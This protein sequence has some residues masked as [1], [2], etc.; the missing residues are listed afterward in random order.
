MC[1][2][3][4]SG[5]R[6]MKCSLSLSTTIESPLIELNS[7]YKNKNK[8]TND[9]NNGE[10]CYDMENFNYLT[11]TKT[12]IVVFIKH[13]S[14]DIN[15]II[16]TFVFVNKENNN[17]LNKYLNLFSNNSIELNVSSH[18]DTATK[19]HTYNQITNEKYIGIIVNEIEF[20]QQ[21]KHTN[22]NL[23]VGNL[24]DCSHINSYDNG[25]Y[26]TKMHEIFSWKSALTINLIVETYVSVN[27]NIYIYIGIN[28]YNEY[29]LVGNITTVPTF[30]QTL[31]SLPI[32]ISE[33][34][35]ASIS[36]PIINTLSSHTKPPTK[37]HRKTPSSSTN[38][39][40]YSPSI[41][42]TV[43]ITYSTSLAPSDTPSL[44][45]SDTPA[46]ALTI[47]RIPRTT[48]PTCSHSLAPGISSTVSLMYNGLS[49]LVYA[50]NQAYNGTG[51]MGNRIYN[52][53]YTSLEYAFNQPATNPSYIPT[54]DAT[55]ILTNDPTSN[56]IS[57]MYDNICLW[58]IG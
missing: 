23:N 25:T 6:N 14:K 15:L 1:K 28:I 5:T 12:K 34:I 16:Q 17:I 29:V 39:S 20:Y 57:F 48:E 10:I 56:V 45:Q 7:H 13:N 51:L 24:Y 8:I 43:S 49:I 58:N 36:I 46:L 40:K 54:A 42:S 30:A 3:L 21:P 31:K 27:K 38:A 55:D 53:T 35:I 26:D 11:S 18:D 22:S 52:I 41:A 37:L 50:L 44:A 19:Y 33:P 32:P 4:L 2:L 47:S 9:I